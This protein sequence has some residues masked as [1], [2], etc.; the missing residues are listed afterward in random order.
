MMIDILVTQR[1][2]AKFAYLLAHG[3]GADMTTP[4]LNAITGLLV[5]RSIAVFRFEFTYMTERKTKGLRRPPPRAEVLKPE[6]LAAIAQL[7]AY[8]N[9][10]PHLFIG[11]KSMGG[12]VASMIAG[13]AFASG[14]VAG[15]VCLGFPFHPPAKLENLRTQHLETLHC[16]TLIVQGELD[17]FGHRGEHERF[18]LDPAIEIAWID[19]GDHDFRPRGVSGFT[20]TGN[21]VAA[22]DATRAFMEKTAS[23]R[24]T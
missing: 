5:D 14:D 13:E 12:R 16:P 11:G 10:P 9:L 1:A 8:E 22:A 23:R 24:K 15:L 21:L 18:K 17:P 19:D 6:Y 4:F 3:A 20:R 7:T 2:D